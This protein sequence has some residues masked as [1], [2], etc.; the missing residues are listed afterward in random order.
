MPAAPTRSVELTW[1]VVSIIKITNKYITYI[2]LSSHRPSS[3]LP[4]IEDYAS[5]ANSKI[6]IVTAGARG[7]EDKKD[8]IVR[9]N[10]EIFRQIVPQLVSHSP[11]CIL[12]VCSYPVDEMSFVAWKLSKLPPQRVIGSGT[13]LESARFRCLI[14]QKL[15]VHPD[16]CQAFV[17]G[18]QGC[19]SIPVWSS[20][21]VA[22]VRLRDVNPDLGTGVDPE[23]WQSIHKEVMESAKEVTC[24]KECGSWGMALSVAR[25][26]RAVLFDSK[27][28]FA[29]STHIKGCRHGVEKDV[30]LSLPCI[31][32]C[33]GVQFIVRQHLSDDEKDCMQKSADR[34]YE[35]QKTLGLDNETKVEC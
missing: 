28:C 1:C 21:S 24:L 6:C 14:A 12:L 33:A 9:Q 19:N 7:S 32:G 17:I 15:D 20:V 30:F 27:E 4:Q 18:E 34:M 16:S 2:Q 5:T 25:I 13:I 35:T 10:T 23:D 26:V 11:N 8:V 22:G 29:I 3:V 31:V